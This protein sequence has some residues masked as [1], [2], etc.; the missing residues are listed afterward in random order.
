MKI[1]K[2]NKIHIN[3]IKHLFE[4]PK[5]MG[6][7]INQESFSTF[8]S[9]FSEFYHQVFVETYLDNLQN[10]HAY[11]IEDKEKNIL[12]IISFYESDDDASWYGT[13]IRSTGNKQ[14]VRLLLDAAIEHNEKNNRLKFYTLWS[15]KHIRLLRKFAFSTKTNKRYDYFDEYI[16]NA[17]N[18]CKFT[19]PWQILFNRTL[20][21]VDT[22]VRCTFLKQQYRIIS[23]AGNI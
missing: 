20:L 2:L 22:V 16:V 3:K 12:G 17:R 23:N 14:I 18:Q 11:G 4:I 13:G 5:F 9:S 1:I 8:D 15:S 10:Y 19:L 6:I 21:P 7:D